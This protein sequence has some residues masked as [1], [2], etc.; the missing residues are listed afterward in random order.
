MNELRCTCAHQNNN[1]VSMKSFFGAPTVVQKHF[2]KSDNTC[3]LNF[4]ISNEMIRPWEQVSLRRALLS[5]HF[6]NVVQAMVVRKPHP[7]LVSSYPGLVS[8][9][10]ELVSSYPENLH[11]SIM[12]KLSEE[13]VPAS[14]AIVT[15][16][17]KIAIEGGCLFAHVDAYR[18]ECE[19][20]TAGTDGPGFVSHF[21]IIYQPEATSV[22]GLSREEF[23][24]F[25]IQTLLVQD[26]KGITKPFLAHFEAII[27]ATTTT[28][29]TPNLNGN[30][31]VVQQQ[32]RL[33]TSCHH[34]D[35]IVSTYNIQDCVCI[36]YA[37]VYHLNLYVVEC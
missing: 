4:A 27:S 31:R 14:C 33:L 37:I 7:V 35:F 24:Q 18:R 1:S 5:E 16:R 26:V 6:V 28:D 21:K 30:I 13:V 20:F 2:F 10:P 3:V 23:R 12:T 19:R 9:Y 8:S 17:S 29:N 34:V 22:C 11:A 36:F 32:V 15:E 25:I